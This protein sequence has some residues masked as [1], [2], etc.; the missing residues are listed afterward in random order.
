[1][2]AGLPKLFKSIWDW[3]LYSNKQAPA[4]DRQVCCRAKDNVLSAPEC[5]QHGVLAALLLQ[6]GTLTV[7][8]SGSCF[9]VSLPG[10]QGLSM[11]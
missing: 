6:P 1:M 10:P 3:N 8:A 5:G 11:C 4:D 7:L 9:V 2:P